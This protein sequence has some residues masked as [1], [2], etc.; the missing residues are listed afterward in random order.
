MAGWGKNKTHQ[1]SEAK[2]DVDP[3]A[4]KMEMYPVAF[5]LAMRVEKHTWS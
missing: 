1:F 5:F 2:K 3:K 4:M